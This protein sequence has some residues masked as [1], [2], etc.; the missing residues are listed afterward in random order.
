LGEDHSRDAFSAELRAA[1]ETINLAF[2]LGII[3][4]EVEKT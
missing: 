4:V 3:R 1:E 2:D